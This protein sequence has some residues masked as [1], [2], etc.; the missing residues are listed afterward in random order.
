MDKARINA[1]L[2]GQRTFAA[3]ARAARTV[4]VVSDETTASS[5]ALGTMCRT[6]SGARPLP[7]ESSQLPP[8]F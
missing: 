8:I 4:I 5:K 3:E 6:R 2:S 7:L 1:I